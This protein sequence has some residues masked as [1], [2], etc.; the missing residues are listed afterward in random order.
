MTRPEDPPAPS[1][2]PFGSAT[3]SQPNPKRAAIERQTTENVRHPGGP[4]GEWSR[5]MRDTPVITL[6]KW[7]DFAH[8]QLD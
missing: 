2:I 4:E 3:D 1:V 6:P 5:G 8:E 7:P